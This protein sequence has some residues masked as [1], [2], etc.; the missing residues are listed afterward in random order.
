MIF[1]IPSGKHR[2]R[3][4]RFGLWWN[5]PVFAWTVMFNESCRYDLGN[6]DQFDTNKL[7]GI[8]Y[9][10]NHHQHSARF[11]WRYW[12]DR[13]EIELT[14]YCYIN[15]RRMIQHIGFVRIGGKYRLQLNVTRLAYVFDVYDLDADKT[16]GGCSIP[17]VHGKKLQYRLGPYFGGNQVAQHEMKIQIEK[18]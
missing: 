2:A 7:T 17:K 14:A 4:F 9:L 6:D 8:G 1:R 13:G 3:P 18:I 12:T 5:R 16:V 10:P 11:G 15:G